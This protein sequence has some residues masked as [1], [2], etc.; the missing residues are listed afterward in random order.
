[1]GEAGGASARV[2]AALETPVRALGWLCGWLVLACVLLTFAVVLVR[3]GLG[4]PA[5]AA[6]E[7]VLHLN[8]VVVLV[9][10]AWALV[11]D[12][13]V[14]VD[15][16]KQGWSPGAQARAEL[17]GIGLLLLPF[18]VFLFWISLDYVGASW[19]MREGSREV[20]GL[21]GVFLVKSLI[22][23]SALLLVLAGVARALRM[24]ALARPGAAAAATPAAA[25]AVHAAAMT[26]PARA[27]AD[28]AGESRRSPSRQSGD[29][30]TGR[31]TVAGDQADD[32]TGR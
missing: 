17:A 6:Q 32:R 15:I 11:R 9:G 23:L 31:G 22:P 13:H 28:L 20:G 18:C 29:V 8:A 10:G 24:V 7:L 25:P 27:G 3:Y 19:A 16:V 21:P 12:Q 1:M 2:A 4:R 26:E 30:A 5:L 14:R